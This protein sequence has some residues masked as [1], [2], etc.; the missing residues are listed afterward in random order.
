MKDLHAKGKGGSPVKGLPKLRS[1]AATTTTSVVVAGESNGLGSSGSTSS[2]QL[3]TPAPSLL[4]SARKEETRQHHHHH[5]QQP[6]KASKVSPANAPADEPAN[7]TADATDISSGRPSNAS[8]ST[9]APSASASSVFLEGTTNTGSTATEGGGAGGSANRHPTSTLP[10]AASEP[11]PHPQRQLQKQQHP[12]R[13][14]TGGSLLATRDGSPASSPRLP[15]QGESSSGSPVKHTR[16]RSTSLPPPPASPAGRDVGFALPRYAAARDAGDPAVATAEAHL[17]LRRG[18]GASGNE[19]GTMSRSSRRGSSDR[20]TTTTAAS[21]QEGPREVQRRLD[22]AV[23]TPSSSGGVAAGASGLSNP[24]AGTSLFPPPPTTEAGGE[25]ATGSATG[26]SEGAPQDKHNGDKKSSSRPS[27]LLACS[28]PP[29]D[30][31]TAPESATCTDDVTSPATTTASAPKKRKKKAKKKTSAAAAA[32][33]FDSMAEEGSAAA[34]ANTN[35]SGASSTGETKG[36]AAANAVFPS[37]AMA[38]APTTGGPSRGDAAAR[39]AAAAA[40]ALRSYGDGSTPHPHQH[41][42]RSNTSSHVSYGAY[43]PGNASHEE[44]SGGGIGNGGPAPRPTPQMNANGYAA[45]AEYLQQAGSS[46]IGNSCGGNMGAYGPPKMMMMMG[47]DGSSGG[48]GGNPYGYYGGGSRGNGMPPSHLAQHRTMH[49]QQQQQQPQMTYMPQGM[50]VQQQ[51][52]GGYTTLNNGGSMRP[53]SASRRGAGGYQQ[54]Q[55]QP[56]QPKQPP[57]PSPPLHRRTMSA[58]L[59]INNNVTTN[60][61]LMNSGNAMMQ[62]QV[63][64]GYTPLHHHHSNSIGGVHHNSSSNTSGGAAAAAGYFNNGMDSNPVYASDTQQQQ[65]ESPQHPQQ[66]NMLYPYPLSFAPAQMYYPP[67]NGGSMQPGGG[68]HNTNSVNNPHHRLLSTDYQ[69]SEYNHTLNSN[70]SATVRG[71]GGYRDG[72]PSRVGAAGGASGGM[73][74]TADAAAVPN[75]FPFTPEV[76]PRLCRL[77]EQEVLTYLTPSL[78]CLQRRRQQLR[79]LAEYITAAL[80]HAGRQTGHEYGDISFYIFGSVNMRTVLPDGDNDVTVEVDGLLSTEAS[81][82]PPPP[83]TPEEAAAQRAAAAMKPALP[84]VTTDSSAGDVDGTMQLTTTADGQPRLAAPAVLS[85]ASGEVLGRVRDYLRN[86]KTP[87]FVDSLVMA[88]VR[89]L[90]LVMEGCNYDITIGQFGGVN[91][92]R[93]LHE[94]DAAI[95]GQHLLKRTLLLLKAWSSFEAHVLGGQAGYIGSYAATVMLISMINTVEFLEDVE[96]VPLRSAAAKR[97]G[98]ASSR[99]VHDAAQQDIVGGAVQSPKRATT[100]G[101][102]PEKGESAATPTP[103]KH[104]SSS[105]SSPSFSPSSA[106]SAAHRGGGGGEEDWERSGDHNDECVAGPAAHASSAVEDQKE[107]ATNSA[108]RQGKGPSIGA[109]HRLSPLTLLARFVKFYAYFDFDHYSVTAFGP[110]PLQKI[111]STPLDL[112][113]LEV[114]AAHNR[115][116]TGD[117]AANHAAAD[118]NF[119]GLTAE[120]EATIGHLIRRRQ[121]PLLT[122]SGVRHLLDEVNQSRRAERQAKHNARRA[123]TAAT[124]SAEAGEEAKCEERGG[125]SSNSRDLHTPVQ[126]DRAGCSSEDAGLMCPSCNTAAFP[127]RDMNVLDPLRWSSNMVRGVCRNHLQRIR[128]AFLE[129]IRLLDVASRQLGGGDGG[130]VYRGDGHLSTSANTATTAAA[131]AGGGTA[132]NAM[133]A[134]SPAS[135]QSALSGTSSCR[136][137]VDNNNGAVPP[138]LGTPASEEDVT[139]DAAAVV[140]NNYNLGERLEGGDDGE[141]SLLY[142]GYP[143]PHSQCTRRE[144]AVLQ[145]LFPRSIDSIRKNSASNCPWNRESA[146]EMALEGV[147]RCPTCACPS[148]LCTPDIHRM[149]E[150][151]LI[152]HAAAAAV[153]SPTTRTSPTA[154]S[155]ANTRA[156][157]PQQQQQPSSSSSQAMNPPLPFGKAALSQQ[158]QTPQQTNSTGRRFNPVEHATGELEEAMAGEDTSEAARSG[159]PLGEAMVP[160]VRMVPAMSQANSVGSTVHT[161]TQGSNGGGRGGNNTHT[162][163]G[164]LYGGTPMEAPHASPLQPQM[165][166][167]SSSSGGGGGAATPSM[168]PPHGLYSPGPASAG[169]METYGPANMGMRMLTSAEE[170]YYAIQSA[171]AAA[172]MH[173][174]MGRGGGGGGHGGPYNPQPQQQQQQQR[175]HA[176]PPHHHQQHNNG[177]YMSSAA[178][179]MPGGGG[180]HP[181]TNGVNNGGP[182]SSPSH[183]TGSVHVGSGSG[184]T[185]QLYVRLGHQH[186]S[187]N[188]GGYNAAS[189]TG[190]GNSLGLMGRTYGGGG[191]GSSS[192]NNNNGGGGSGGGG[193][194]YGGWTPN[195]SSH[196][197]QQLQQ[198]QQNALAPPVPPLQQQPQRGPFGEG[199]PSQAGSRSL[200]GGGGH[201]KAPTKETGKG[202]RDTATLTQNV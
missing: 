44:G 191:G 85:I 140:G 138:I 98:S 145:L 49:A 58:Q 82:S 149:C 55:P 194:G 79:T 109:F 155:G 65:Q 70:G 94:M 159:G 6:H 88:E 179:M 175:F 152:F 3:E 64:G 199:G 141:D 190:S 1:T 10:S 9:A 24:P 71:G 29:P 151:Q 110:L 43:P 187:P 32:A 52:G 78:P 42:N 61:Y 158:K 83:P 102:T 139:A 84:P 169:T 87:I 99:M 113:Y 23:A 162:N 53:T 100:G 12:D 74:A 118:V 173:A 171:A 150:P 178:M 7:T 115:P 147:P 45:N 120:G 36:A 89:V 97:A 104:T 21:L 116:L 28:P 26:K 124:V 148:L 103:T 193:G 128:C 170:D 117:T 13:S 130:D 125:S 134:A 92:V 136:S 182:T 18:A 39:Q 54:P 161:G 163:N 81:R 189:V 34:G 57:Q 165:L 108:D 51:G 174:N 133:D 123:A 76:S 95:G 111:N 144:V 142:P 27:R 101:A 146:E 129:G 68:A 96:G 66:R 47:S 200:Y 35:N 202:D 188:S 73:R 16:A 156:P 59:Y 25:A 196:P 91:C 186:A 86:S 135:Q 201:L 167:N 198:Q 105:S 157:A 153:G 172:A 112:S 176:H 114:D 90:K 154:L 20:S 69:G 56:Q 72:V 8:A 46:N 41:S 48:V 2:V 62:V 197:S 106:T 166:N 30:S 181:N 122:V 37:P 40:T 31:S 131:A 15:A 60:N 77:V 14:A 19:V 38:A 80:R 180:G 5:Q 177:G 160:P 192:S 137:W 50:M 127:V 183:T 195:S 185:A 184:G 22:V 132:A 119:L 143:A 67:A 164:V 33:A 17:P 75:P 107:D 11:T 168:M 126:L 63:G 4:N 93:F 121:Q